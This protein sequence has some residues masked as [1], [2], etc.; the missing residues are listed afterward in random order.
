[1][2][3]LSAKDLIPPNK[4]EYNSVRRRKLVSAKDQ[5][6]FDTLK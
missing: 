1:M 2:F 3:T 4:N 6:A 5:Y